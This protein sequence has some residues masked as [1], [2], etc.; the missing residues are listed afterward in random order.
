MQAGDGNA[1]KNRQHEALKTLLRHVPV[2][3]GESEAEI[4]RRLDEALKKT[5][6]PNPLRPG[7]EQSV[8]EALE[9]ARGA[10]KAVGLEIHDDR[11]KL[12]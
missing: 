12:A 2:A 3:E 4:R 6:V 10:L 1:R 5:H 7:P 8:E 11:L 9:N